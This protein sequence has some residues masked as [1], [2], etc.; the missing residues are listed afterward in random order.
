MNDLH[1]KNYL[2]GVSNSNSTTYNVNS[3]RGN[4]SHMN[5]EKSKH[6]K[7]NKL[8]SPR[9]IIQSSD[10]PDKDCDLKSKH[11]VKPRLLTGKLPSAFDVRYKR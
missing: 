11:Q 10:K 1:K 5:N 2:E 4:S 9:L 7:E 8:M 6:E 3:F